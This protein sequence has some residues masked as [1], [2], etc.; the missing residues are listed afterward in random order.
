MLFIFEQA[1]I[2]SDV[3]TIK[4]PKSKHLIVIFQ[5]L[6]CNNAYEVALMADGTKFK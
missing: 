2:N 1:L 6:C 5:A 4:H 3:D